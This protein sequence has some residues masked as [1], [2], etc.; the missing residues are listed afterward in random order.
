M[1]EAIQSLRSS[2]ITKY[3]KF[4]NNP[5]NFPAYYRE[6]SSMC[7]ASAAEE[8]RSTKRL[9]IL[10]VWSRILTSAARDFGMDAD[11]DKAE[12]ASHTI[13]V[14]MQNAV[15]NQS[16]PETDVKASEMLGQLLI[17][18]EKIIMS[19]K[20]P[21][22]AN[23]IRLFASE[24]NRHISMHADILKDHKNHLEYISLLRKVISASAEITLPEADRNIIMAKYAMLEA[25]GKEYQISDIAGIMVWSRNYSSCSLQQRK[26]QTYRL[27]METLHLARQDKKEPELRC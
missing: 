19:K 22:F 7:A 23:E 14:L 17:L 11:A 4:R 10:T 9:M 24:R 2:I 20:N 21:I 18:H 26:K 1:P 15:G 16:S 3:K 25:S 13:S 27:V 8:S 5:R 12:K 6:I